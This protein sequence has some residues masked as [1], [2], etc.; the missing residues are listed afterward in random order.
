MEARFIG[1]IGGKSLWKV[2]KVFEEG[3][4]KLWLFQVLLF[5]DIN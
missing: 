4:I 2:W 1:Q 3:R 5:L